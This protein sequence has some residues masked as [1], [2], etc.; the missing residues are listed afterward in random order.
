MTNHSKYED[1]FIKA[2]KVSS[3]TSEY[4]KLKKRDF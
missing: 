2:N 1:A 3:L 4:D